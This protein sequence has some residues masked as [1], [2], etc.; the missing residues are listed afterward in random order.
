MGDKRDTLS[1]LENLLPDTSVYAAMVYGS[2]ARDEEFNDID[3]ALFTDD[4]ITSIVRE[5]PAILDLQRFNDL[6]M[7]IRHRVLEEGELIYCSDKNRFY[8]TI[9]AFVKA[10]ED[11]KPL[12]DAHLTGVKQR[13]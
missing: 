5:A 7:Y 10:Y 9:I 3:V 12:H 6:P 4:D 2:Y 11:F 8:D 13:G 1:V